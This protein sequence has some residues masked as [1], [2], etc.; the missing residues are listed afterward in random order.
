VIQLLPDKISVHNGQTIQWRWD[1]NFSVSVTKGAFESKSVNAEPDPD[2]L[3]WTTPP[4]RVVGNPN[5]TSTC[6]YTSLPDPMAADT[7]LDPPP[8]PP[9]NVVIVDNS[10]PQG[11]RE[12]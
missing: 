2:G 3:Y 11:C 8:P 10:T 9:P 1:N 7:D 4:L 5:D 12:K 6:I